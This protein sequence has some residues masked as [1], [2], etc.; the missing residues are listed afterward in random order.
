MERKLL[1]CISKI[2]K[3]DKIVKNKYFLVNETLSN[4]INTGNNINT[5]EAIR[6]FNGYS[7]TTIPQEIESIEHNLI[8]Q[9]LLILV[10]CN[11][12]NKWINNEE[13]MLDYMEL[14]Q[15]KM[16][17]RYGKRNSNDFIELLKKISILIEAKFDSKKKE[18][19]LK[20][21]EEVEDE[22]EKLEDNEEFVEEITRK[23]RKITNEIKMIDETLN[24]KDMIQKEYIRRNENLP[25]EEKIFSIRI[26]SKLMV[27]ERD[28]KIQELV[29]EPRDKMI[30]ELQEQN[31]LLYLTLQSQV[32]TVERASKYE[33]ERKSI[34]CENRELK[35]KCE[36]ME[37]DYSTKL[38]EEIR[39]V[40]NKYE[41]KIYK[42]EKENSFLRKIINTLQKTVDKFIH[43]VCNKFSV[44]SEDEFIKDFEFENDIYLD[45]EKQIEYEEELED[46]YEM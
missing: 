15:E 20:L 45:P 16:E 39:K 1:Y 14:F 46:K 31:S 43:W 6:D 10:G 2:S 12:L 26:L 17:R 35:E 33:K 8:Y 42:L 4:L 13:V 24:N 38:K 7:W 5:V 19:I 36:N 27:D 25:L 37:N 40:E 44:S 11:F 30:K 23:K 32:N 9:N 29:V 41:D 22:L 3:K 28:E 18:K 34:M 21:K